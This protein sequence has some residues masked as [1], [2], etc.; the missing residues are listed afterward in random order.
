MTGPSTSDIV[1]ISDARIRG[2]D[3]RE[4]G[5]PLVELRGALRID[6]RRSDA[7]GHYA[8]TREGVRDRLVQADRNL[9]KG[10]NLLIIEAYRP[11]SLQVSIFEEYRLELEQATPGLTRAEAEVLASRYVS[12]LEVAPHVCGAAIDLTLV[13]TDGV[14]LDLGCPEAATP[15]QSDGACYTDAPNISSRAREHRAML[16][17][18]LGAA[19][20][21][22]YPTEW[23]H[24]S[25][26]DRYWAHVTGQSHSLYGPWHG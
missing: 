3:V 4:C 17:E 22:N 23:W 16:G 15:E 12:P 25:Y 9:P 7:Q 11:P 1:L 8:R 6:E 24:W 19:G 5:E 20:M 13:D 14:E 2:I 26:G 10:I 18:A 21:V